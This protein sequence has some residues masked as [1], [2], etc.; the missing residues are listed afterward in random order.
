[1]DGRLPVFQTQVRNAAMCDTLVG[2]AVSAPK[3][4]FP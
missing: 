1:M 2:T 4:G 3:S